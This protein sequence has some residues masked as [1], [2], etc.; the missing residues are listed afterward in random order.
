MILISFFPCRRHR[1]RHNRLLSPSQI[2]LLIY[3]YVVSRDLELWE[4]RTPWEREKER[5]KERKKE[6]K[7][8]GRERK[9]SLS[10]YG[11]VKQYRDISLQG[12]LA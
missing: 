3:L 12:A 4:Q 9:T 7:K 1:R 6:R 2:D 8:E 5:E 10:T 11:E